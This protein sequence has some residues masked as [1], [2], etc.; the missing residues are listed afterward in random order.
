M[1]VILY[2]LGKGLEYV[3]SN[4]KE[5]HEIIG[6]SDSFATIK[7]FKGKPFYMLEQ[8]P[9]ISFDYLIITVKNRKESWKIYELLSNGPYKI[10][11]A[12]SFLCLCK[13]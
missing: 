8:L 4:L 1:K 2:G 7:V 13:E 11:M 9:E 12:N 10:A 6:Y 3:E 5:A